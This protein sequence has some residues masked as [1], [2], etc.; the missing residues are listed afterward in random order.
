M[1]VV[2]E[3][4]DIVLKLGEEYMQKTGR[5]R[6]ISDYIYDRLPSEHKFA[7][8]YILVLLHYGRKLKSAGVWQ[9]AVDEQWDTTKIRDFVKGK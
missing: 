8:R 7:K 1:K 9:R 5:Q 3:T 4:I 2:T 6:G